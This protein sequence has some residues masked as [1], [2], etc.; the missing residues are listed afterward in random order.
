M[1][2]INIHTLGVG[3]PRYVLPSP[4]SPATD[5]RF[6]AGFCCLRRP[7]E[8]GRTANTVP[9]CFFFHPSHHHNNERRRNKTVPSWNNVLT[10]PIVP[11]Y[12]QLRFEKHIENNI[13]MTAEIEVS[14]AAAALKI[15]KKALK[16]HNASTSDE[17]MKL[18]ALAKL[19]AEKLKDEGKMNHKIIQKWIVDASDIFVVDGKNVV[20]LTK[21]R[22]RKESPGNNNNNNNPTDDD[23][24]TK[25]KKAKVVAATDAS[26]ITQKDESSIKEW[27]QT[28]KIVVK[29]AKDDEEG[30]KESE[31]INVDSAYYPFLSF[32]DP[33]CKSAVAHPLLRQCTEVNGFTKPSPI[34][35]QAWP[36]LLQ[37]TQNGRKR[38]V[39]G[40]A[41]TGS[42]K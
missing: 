21:D 22:K 4:S 9:C 31:Q 35:A 37:T 5:H 39:V 23:V 26:I 28:H 15:A 18:K 17:T 33:Q 11:F 29:H 10:T 38:D 13:K 12:T 27:R 20:L 42:G 19:V 14:S 24:D 6:L 36:I 41:E 40:I 1:M 30:K 3:L 8:I 25:R 32:D 16:K 34:Q 2:Y 7:R